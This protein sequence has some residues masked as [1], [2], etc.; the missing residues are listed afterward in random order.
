MIYSKKFL[1]NIRLFFIFLLI[2]FCIGCS[3]KSS[4]PTNPNPERV[5][6]YDV[7]LKDYYQEYEFKPDLDYN[8][9]PGV[10]G[11][12]YYDF[13]INTSEVGQAY[14][15][16]NISFLSNTSY[17]DT[18]DAL[19]NNKNVSIEKINLGN[20]LLD[21]DYD[22]INVSISVTNDESVYNFVLYYRWAGILMNGLTLGNTFGAVLKDNYILS[23]PVANIKLDKYNFDNNSNSLSFL[24]PIQYVFDMQ[25][26]SNISSPNQSIYKL[27]MTFEQFADFYKNTGKDDY[28]VDYGTQT[29]VYNSIKYKT[30]YYSAV[31]M[32]YTSDGEYGSVLCTPLITK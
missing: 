15:G 26:I 12:I 8:F 2:L 18:I 29:V 19:K 30:D 27:K 11:D 13:M 3:F 23:T 16:D 28:T 21:S 5:V 9:L 7:V 4:G 20:I 22:V 32:K 24:F 17:E 25:R 14:K 1:L 31:S 6:S 10:L